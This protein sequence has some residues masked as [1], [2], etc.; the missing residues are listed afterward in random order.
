MRGLLDHGLGHA[1][2]PASKPIRYSAR[3][4]ER[5][6]DRLWAAQTTRL[7]WTGAMPPHGALGYP[8][9]PAEWPGFNPQ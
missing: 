2:T 6:N 4:E 9:L 1:F 8:Q 5:S 3:G 7:E